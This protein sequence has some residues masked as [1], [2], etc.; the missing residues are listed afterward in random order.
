MSLEISVLNENSVLLKKKEC[1]IFTF[2][3]LGNFFIEILFSR[4]TFIV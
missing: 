2:L 1:L 3:D 4:M